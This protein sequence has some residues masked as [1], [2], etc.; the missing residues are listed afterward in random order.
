[1]LVVERLSDAVRLGHPVLAVVRGSAV[2]QDGASNGLTAPNGPS[3]QRVVR[4]A[5]ANAGLSAAEV[6]AVE[7]HGTGTMLGDPIEAQAL[8]AT[9]GQGRDRPCWLGSVKSNMG[10]TQAAAGVAG[11]IKMVMA[12]RHEVLPATLHVDEPSP[13]VD[14][15]AGAVSLLTE[16]VSWPADGGPRRAGVSSFG[17]SGTNAHVII[18]GAP[19]V[20]VGE[21]VEQ[22]TTRVLPW[23]LSAKTPAA[24]TAQASR[25]LTH[26][27]DNPELDDA[28][29]AWTL[30]GRSMFGRRAVILGRDRDELERGLAELVAVETTAGEK[31][32]S[33]GKTAF[34]FPGQ[35]AQRLGMGRELYGGYPVFAEAFDAAVT[36]LDRHLLR[37]LRDVM[38][39]TN[40]NLLNST[41]FAQPALFAMEVALFGLL[42][43]W[44]LRPDY[45]IGHS[46]GEIAAAHVAEVLS[47]ENAAALVVARGRLMQSLPEGGAMVAVSATED[48]VRPLL[49]DGTDIAAI[50]ATNSVVVSG[51]GDAVNAV[52]ERLRS[53]GHRTHRLPVSH[54]FHSSLMEPMLDDF[55]YVARELT[56]GRPVFPI[57][58]NLTG[59][60]CGADF[61]SAGYWVRH[62]REA[63]RF[64]DGVRYLGSEGVTRF[65]EVG[66][67]SGLT[68]SV[69]QTLPDV[70]SVPTLAKDR[71]ESRALLTGL[72]DAFAS[73]VDVGWRAV[74]G[75][76]ALAD[77]PTYAFERRRF[78]LPANGSGP[79]DA[80]GLGL[81]GADHAL[82]GAVVES[83][84]SGGVVLT[85]KLSTSSQPWLADHAVS[86][87]VLF[88]GAGF[89]ELVIRAGDEVGCP[90]VEELT[91][92]APLVLL[93]GGVAVQVL[94]GGP[95][96]AGSRAV[97]I[98]SRAE[99]EASAW[100]LHADGVLALQESGAGAE[101]AVWPPPGAHP[102]DVSDAYD[103]IAERGYQYGPAFHGL[104][105]MW[106]RG[107]ELFAEVSVPEDAAADGLGIH[108]VL[109]DSALHAIVLAAG[110]RQMALPFSWQKV[111]LHASG[112]TAA[113]VR[114]S[115]SGPNAVSIDLADGLGLPVLSVRSRVARPV[116]PDQLAAAIGGARAGE[117]FEVVWSPA[118]ID[119]PA[120]VTATTWDTL[121]ESESEADQA[122][123]V[124][125]EVP[126]SRHGAVAGAYAGV[127]RALE[128]LQ[129]W[130][131]RQSAQTLLVTT[132][133]AVAL[134][135]EHLDNLGAAAVW[136]L[137]RAAQTENPGRVLLADVDVPVT[138]VVVSAI[139]A[140]AEPQVVVRQGIAHI[141][142]VRP[143]HASETVLTPPPDGAWR[144][145]IS[146][147][148]TFENLVLQPAPIADESLAPGRV[149]IRTTAIAA[150][151]RDVMIALGMYP[152]DANMGIEATG[153]VT[154][155]GA[156][157][158]GVAVGDYVMG[159]FPE[160]SGSDAITDSRVVMR[161]P[162][163]WS[164]AQA[165]S[166]TV[167]FATA[168]YALNRLAS[169][170]AGQ[171]VLVHAAT[172]GVG[173]AAVQL[174]RHWGLE[175]FATA[176]RG[177]WDTLRALGFDDD[178]IG[179]S[180][181]L[182]FEEKFR[183]VTGGR[184]VDVVLNSLAGDFVDA[185]LR[186]LA[187]GG[188][189]LEMGK[190]DIRD[191]DTVGA[192]HPGVH[193]RAFDLFEAGPDGIALI[194]GSLSELFADKTIE[195]LPATTFDVRRAPAAMRY[196]SQARH[197]GKVVLTMPDAWSW[198][199]VLITGGTGMAG[200]VVA[201]HLV[202]RYGVSD[203]I[204]LSRR[205]LEAEG[206]A[207]LVAELESAGSRVRVIAAD[208][209]DR[210]ALATALAGVELTAV[211]HAAGVLDDA[212][213]TSLTPDRVD[214]VLEAKVNA[215]WNLH[216]LTRDMNV[217]AFVMFSSMA[218]LVGGSG[219]ANYSA[220]NAFLDAL[221]VQRR[222]QGLPAMSLGWGLW[223]QAS[224]MT[225]KLSPADLARL[226]RDGI[227]A[228][229]PD[230]VLRLF[231]DALVADEPY[232]AAARID[233]AALRTKAAD[234]TLPPMFL[235]L[236]GPTR[237]HVDDTLAAAQS[238]SALAQR[239]QSLAPED[240]LSA[241]LDLLR[242]HMA[243]V[244]GL[245]HPEAI[246]PDLAFQ[247]HGFDSLTAVELRNRLKS[248]T[249][250]TLSPTLIFDYPNP[251]KL[252]DYIR[253]QV[254]D[255]PEEVGDSLEPG[256]VELSRAVASIPI[257]RLRQAGVL[258]MLLQ[259][260]S[261]GDQ[262]VSVSTEQ[263][264]AD[265]DLQQLLSAAESHDDG[266]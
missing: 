220:A 49:T 160:G 251:A 41:E 58:S 12:L 149:R 264:I 122:D 89:V 192:Q 155:I 135:G 231:D 2:N 96:E 83:P 187:G 84:D 207:D 150:N 172:G 55:S 161:V 50:N 255:D 233:R 212:V 240:Q 159:L 191:A 17:I 51:V 165:A 177:K 199:T 11:V 244:L 243:T 20:A 22:P 23:V 261:A 223:E 82:L 132:Q 56:V 197:I 31:V 259:L 142:R 257:K 86:G 105:A 245:P 14:W 6:D 110:E 186:L 221:A 180:R 93:P 228:L 87:V 129:T 98:F 99:G 40:E 88:P 250:L 74:C 25:L 154:E 63:V 9:Y 241:V 28:D 211:I 92:H 61:G 210:D 126:A 19:P 236:V 222:G 146:E 238:K 188:V 218:A 253:S 170:R 133:G 36:E 204:L 224:A 119:S 139:V 76:G 163:G 183:T 33:P 174:A 47:L 69:E 124:V 214:A 66:P 78:W 35:G 91:L 101:L 7:G 128:V 45:L 72:A 18:E 198:G 27:E 59:E 80:E 109:L 37:P 48:E 195:P 249:G 246:H 263:N 103:V 46:I 137:V 237:R 97:A 38:W 157:V 30:A 111:V 52:A 208:A 254:V 90:V 131:G 173:S 247:D 196:L 57:V 209:A 239:L 95:D 226:G 167:A 24:L 77:L 8:L 217:S 130:L 13:H 258:D 117:L 262:P 108:P 265:M 140:T 202:G 219:Q 39:G 182:E 53:H 153:L 215:A 194:L 152:G 256:E 225:D 175:V 107:N 16:A 115:P 73:G 181:S 176:S 260:A 190:T 242:S 15:S 156:G 81:A 136:G 4:A 227:L 166:A 75:S 203:L 162:R 44:D 32:A 1:M 205:G 185:S 213:L 42:E 193:Y 168:F 147:A 189:F 158:D 144:L 179:D 200:G 64:A 164:H 127:H 201:R 54:A 29:I 138:E 113:R 134:P 120:P 100:T 235:D 141:P 171:S 71:P 70:V 79:A 3:Q 114:I 68:A 62:I 266:E 116:T 118:D 106:R 230:D 94:V 216:E 121:G 112:A 143:S 252:A 232:L 67:A 10:H 206:V 60:A 102:V 65:I 43:S 104:T 34:I 148:G 26:L 125:F 21:A 145:G 151:F 248:A 234:H 169:A 5:L 178:H 123:V 229:A 85:G 184:G